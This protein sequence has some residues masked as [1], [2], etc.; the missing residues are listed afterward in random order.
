[1]AFL[2]FGYS[3]PKSFLYA[4]CFLSAQTTI[5]PTEMTVKIAAVV[6]TGGG[7]PKS[8]SVARHLL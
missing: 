5:C 3:F 4:R 8:S 1:M 2:P 6:D 7:R